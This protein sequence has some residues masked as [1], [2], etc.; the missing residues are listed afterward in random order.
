MKYL[1][2]FANTNYDISSI[3]LREG[4]TLQKQDFFEMDLNNIQLKSFGV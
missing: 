3:P 4:M 1:E 2:Y